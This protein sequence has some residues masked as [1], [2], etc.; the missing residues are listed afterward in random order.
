MPVLNPKPL[1]FSLKQ[2][3]ALIAAGYPTPFYIYDEAG[4]RRSARE[5]IDAFSWNP[6]FR[7]FFAAKALPNPH[8]L[9]IL[10][11][12]GCGADCSSL[13]ELLLAERAGIVGREIM[14][15]SNDTP[16][17]EFVRAKKLGAIINLDDLSHLPFLERHAGLPPLLSFR[18]NPGN[19]RT[20]NAII[21]KPEEAKY[22]LTRPQ[23]TE[24]YHRAKEKGVTRFGLHTM[25]ASN[26]LNPQYF[27]ET[28]QMLFDLVIELRCELG[29]SFE[30]VNLGGG[31]GIPYH[32]EQSP[33]DLRII[34]SGIRALYDKYRLAPLKIYLECGRCI[35][36]PHGYQFAHQ[37]QGIL[38][39][40]QRCA[41]SRN[42]MAP[43]FYYSSS[44]RRKA[45]SFN[46]QTNSHR[47]FSFQVMAHFGHFGSSNMLLYPCTASAILQILSIV[48]LNLSRVV[49]LLS[50]PRGLFAPSQ[51]ALWVGGEQERT[52]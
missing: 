5:L 51:S 36:G 4:I 24:A 44:F 43:F 13:P 3:Q 48:V 20:G 46:F 1:P 8:I 38:V 27:V 6:G 11:E 19:E 17:E 31:I 35:T 50:H 45:D 7:E 10:Q 47:D 18:Y 9:K 32:P 39:S 40:R 22:G 26:E 49:P 15:T 25:V 34:S 23:L 29:I 30:F 42:Y 21:G 2:I 52:R 33:V 37:S 41:I 28:A 14:F 12:E 16:D